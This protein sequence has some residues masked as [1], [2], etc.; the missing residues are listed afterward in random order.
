M[1]G[2]TRVY[3]FFIIIFPF[4]LIPYLAYRSQDWLILLGL[5]FYFAGYTIA[6]IKQK[7]IYFIPVFLCIWFWYTYG[8]SLFHNVTFFFLC[9]TAGLVLYLVRKELERYIDRTIPEIEQNRDYN[10][11]L[12]K[13]NLKLEQFKTD[14][15]GRK[16][17][18][19]IIEDIKKDIFFK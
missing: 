16:I 2:I 18:P 3:F 4:L 19:E 1:K 15:P 9:L 11:K 6:A 14:N 7:T 10:L 12:E 13:M 8:F 17:T 5:P